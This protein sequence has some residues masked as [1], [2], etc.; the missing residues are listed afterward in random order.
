MH[1]VTK[2]VP[3]AGLHGAGDT[4]DHGANGGEMGGRRLVDWRGHR[5]E[6]ARTDNLIGSL[7]FLHQ[8][9][10]APLATQRA[11]ADCSLRA[12]RGE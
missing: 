8:T 10:P 9:F 11:N 6:Y 2:Q 1:K 3:S 4:V 7:T 5:G 12:W